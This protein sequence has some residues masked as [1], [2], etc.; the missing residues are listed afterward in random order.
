MAKIYIILLSIICLSSAQSGIFPYSG[1]RYTLSK[2]SLKKQYYPFL[3]EGIK[4]TLKLPWKNM[5][6]AYQ[7]SFFS[8]NFSIS[9]VSCK[10]VSY[11][12]DKE[13]AS[14]LH[15]KG[16]KVEVNKKEPSL[17]TYLALITT[18]NSL[19]Y[20]CFSGLGQYC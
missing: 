18:F 11:D 19:E 12:I 6:E 4:K 15:A 9:S 14:T 3:R 17:P 10:S 5:S 8:F 2:A 16:G 13:K 1:M 7:V 20:T